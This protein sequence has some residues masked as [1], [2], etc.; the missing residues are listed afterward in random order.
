RSGR[1]RA[2]TRC[3][4]YRRRPF[5]PVGLRSRCAGSIEAMGNQP[6]AAAPLDVGAI[7][8]DFPILAREVNGRP[9]VYL[10]SAAASQKPQ[11]VIDAIA[12]YYGRHHANVHRGAH[13]LSVEATE[14]YEE[15]RRKL[16]AF[17]GA[18]SPDSVVFTRNATEAINLVAASWGRANLGPGDEVVLSHA[19][20]HANIV[21]WHLLAR[22]RG[23]VLKP[24]GLT[25]D[26]RL[27]L[28]ALAAALTERTKL[29]T[30]FHMS[31]VLGAVNDLP[32]I[33]RLAHEAGALFLVDGA[34]G[35]PHMSLD[36]ATSG[37]DFYALSGHKMLGPTGIGALWAREEVLDAMPPF[38][39]GGEMISRVSMLESSY[40]AIPQ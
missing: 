30:T 39:G 22:E 17:I 34:Q 15:A 26:H 33:A 19:E 24:V 27:D 35:A 6:Q 28:A 13:T 21:P 4:V 9:L 37:C 14:L 18:P 38:L 8:A 31:N 2:A 5:V 20:H 40:A 3:Q 16:A 1:A 11:Q 12:E 29:V 36:V 10:D 32:A 23:I 25:A 7:R